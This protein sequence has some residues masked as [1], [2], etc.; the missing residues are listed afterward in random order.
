MEQKILVV[1][2]A[3]GASCVRKWEDIVAGTILALV[4]LFF[5]SFEVYLLTLKFFNLI[6]SICFIGTVFIFM[7]AGLSCIDRVLLSTK[8]E[9]TIAY[10]D[11]NIYI[12]RKGCL[13]HKRVEIPFQNVCGIEYANWKGQ[14]KWY[15]WPESFKIHFVHRYGK[16]IQYQMSVRFGLCLTEEEKVSEGKAIA[17][18]ILPQIYDHLYAEKNL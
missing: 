6:M 8:A 16:H 13:F 5:L 14:N 2:R 18:V 10:D 17:G 3:K 7:Y 15:V 4:G 11:R 12:L 9:E 1:N